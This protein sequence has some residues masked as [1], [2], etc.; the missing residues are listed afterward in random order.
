MFV[1]TADP[2]LQDPLESIELTTSVISKATS[3]GLVK[4]RANNKKGII[5]SPEVFDIFKKLMKSDEDNATGSIQ[6]LCKLFSGECCSYHYATEGN[7]IISQNTPFCICSSTQLLNARN[8]I[9]KMDH[10]GLVDRILFATPLAYRPML[11]EM[12][13]AKA[14]LSREI[15]D[16]FQELFHNIHATERNT[17]FYFSH[18]AK[19]LHREK[20]Y[21]FVEDVNEAIREGKVSTKTKMPELMPRL[22][23][24]FN[25]FNH[26]MT[27]LL[28]GLPSTPPPASISRQTFQDGSAFVAHLESQ[29]DIPCQV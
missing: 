26:A 19:E 16:D 17:E 21:Q 13:T 6:L 25:V 11:S 28:S 14:Q 27:N 10:N 9:A 3:S 1:T 20:M 22:A 15:V 8:L 29:K 7:I 23:V 4:L 18:D 5:L 2:F 24:P 12:E